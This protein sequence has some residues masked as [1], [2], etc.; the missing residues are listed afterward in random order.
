MTIELHFPNQETIQNFL[1]GYP[2]TSNYKNING[3]AALIF[4]DQRKVIERV[5]VGVHY[6]MC[7]LEIE[8]KNFS[9][10]K[11][12]LLKALHECAN[13][14]PECATHGC[15]CFLATPLKEQIFSIRIRD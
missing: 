4:A 15:K 12:N 3:F 14:F 7:D 8:E 5:D 9:A 2:L 10:I 1:S 6:L 11:N 13:P